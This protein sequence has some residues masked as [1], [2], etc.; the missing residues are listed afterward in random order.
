MKWN[1]YTIQTT[2]AAADLVVSMLD[3]FGIEGVEIEDKIPLTEEDTAKMFIDILPELPPD[4][5]VSYMSFYLEAG[6]DHAE[7][8]AQVRTGLE[9]LRAFVDVG[10]A[11]ITESETE[12]ID[13]INNWKEFFHAFTIKAESE[14]ENAFGGSGTRDGAYASGCRD[15][16]IRPTWEGAEAGDEDRILIEIDPGISFGTGKHETTQLCIRQLMKYVREGDEVL[17]LGCGSGI[18]SIVSLKL[19]A[20]HLVGTDIDEECLTSAYANF[21]VNHLARELGDFY[22]GNLINDAQ[23]R[24]KVGGGR[25]DIAV[26]N[27]LADVI[28]PMAPFISVCLKPGGIFIASGIIDFKEQEVITA[29]EASGLKIVEITHQGEWVGITARRLWRPSQEQL[30]ADK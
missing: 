8:L 28:I 15:I 19:G 4:D 26:A 6:A 23:L 16:R 9:G 22:M 20:G 12:D 2:T 7:L 17:D 18:L 25:Y 11:E 5:G 24:E 13:W 21:E 29:I 14:S 27:I 1:K 3:D 30:A 10:S